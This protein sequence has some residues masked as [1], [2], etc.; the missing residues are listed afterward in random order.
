VYSE[1]TVLPSPPLSTCFVLVCHCRICNIKYYTYI[2]CKYKI[3]IKKLFYIIHSYMFYILFICIHYEYIY[4]HIY[5]RRTLVD[6]VY[7]FPLKWAHW[8]FS[9]RQEM[10][11]KLSAK[12]KFFI[13]SQFSFTKNKE[14]HKIIFTLSNSLNS[15]G[16]T[17]FQDFLLTLLFFR[18]KNTVQNIYFT[19]RKFSAL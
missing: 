19:G 6:L 5:V 16:E 12:N 1:T 8:K 15:V 13:F 17:N 10:N 11:R 7:G 3:Y 9:L 14:Y 18:K 4:V 2:C